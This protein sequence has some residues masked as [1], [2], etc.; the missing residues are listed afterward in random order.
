M[1]NNVAPAVKFSQKTRN[2]VCDASKGLPTVGEWL[3]RIRAI[4]DASLTEA[5]EGI[6]CG[7]EGRETL[8][9]TGS[10]SM[11]VV[12]WYNGKVEFSYVS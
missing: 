6:W 8:D 4:G 5:V 11:L 12:G 3:E 1:T 2:A 7:K 10:R 9:L